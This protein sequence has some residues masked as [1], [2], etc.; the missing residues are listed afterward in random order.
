[1]VY[2]RPS[3]LALLRDVPICANLLIT[4]MFDEGAPAILCCVGMLWLQRCTGQ[5][6]LAAVELAARAEDCSFAGAAGLLT[7]GILPAMRHCCEHLL[8]DDAVLIPAA[9][10]VYVQARPE[11]TWHAFMLLTGKK[12]EHEVHHM[13]PHRRQRCALAACAVWT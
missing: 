11:I 4:D 12:W 10:T 7:S 3:D 1:M 9:A 5:G 2:K 13:L 8:A 6:S